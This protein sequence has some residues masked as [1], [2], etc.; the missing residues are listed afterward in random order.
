VR[1]THTGL[2]IPHFA[3]KLV[4]ILT[5]SMVL[6]LVCEVEDRALFYRAVPSSTGHGL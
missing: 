2:D 4:V 5:I 6:E 1:G 3:V